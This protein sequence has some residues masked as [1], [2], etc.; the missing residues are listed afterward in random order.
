MQPPRRRKEASLRTPTAQR[1]SLKKVSDVEFN[2]LKANNYSFRFWKPVPPGYKMY[3]FI[4][5][6]R[7]SPIIMCVK[8]TSAMRKST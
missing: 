8:V 5:K 6:A 3:K 7:L 2:L 4:H 1:R